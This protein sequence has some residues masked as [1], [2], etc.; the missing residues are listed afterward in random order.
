MTSPDLGSEVRP[1]WVRSDVFPRH[2]STFATT[3]LVGI[4]GRFDF[5]M[6]TGPSAA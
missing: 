3:L 1:N 2:D 6:W 4:L 5:S